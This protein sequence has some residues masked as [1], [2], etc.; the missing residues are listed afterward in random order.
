MEQIK[1]KLSP[2][3][4]IVFQNNVEVHMK[5]IQIGLGQASNNKVFV[6]NLGTTL[7]L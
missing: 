1:R 6:N 3:N 2:A 7:K 4:Q 5:H